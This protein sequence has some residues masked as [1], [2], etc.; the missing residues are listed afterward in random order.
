MMIMKKN[1]L[2]LSFLVT[3]SV[4]SF[5]QSSGY[6]KGEIY[7]GYSNGQ[8]DTGNNFSSSGNAVRD[9]FNNR[10][11]FNGFEAAGVYNVSRYFGLKADVSGTYHRSGSFAFPVTTG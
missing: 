5:A 8:V 11:N 1:A 4:I 6:K 2:A 3:M 10:T 9:F 7:A